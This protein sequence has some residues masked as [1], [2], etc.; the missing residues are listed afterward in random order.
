M[1]IPDADAFLG[2]LR[3]QVRTLARTQRQDPVTVDLLVSTTKRFAS[4]PEHRID[5]H[6]LLASEVDRLR[7]RLSASPPPVDANA[8]GVAQLVAAC[9]S[10]VEPLARILGVLGRWGDG[11]ESDDVANILLTLS[12]QPNS[13]S[14]LVHLHRYPVVLLLWAYGTGLAVA[15]RWRA[16][17]DLLSHPVDADSGE[18]TEPTRLVDIPAR[19]FLDGNRNDFW[20]RLPGLE[21]RKTPASDHIFAVLDTWRTSFAPVVSDFEGLHDIWEIL[22]SL[23]YSETQV[24]EEPNARPPWTHIGRNLWRYRSRRRILERI[25]SDLRRDLLDAG[26]SGGSKT[27]LARTVESYAAFVDPLTWP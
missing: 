8:D 13:Q 3:D 1:R 10:K 26:F 9:E 7:R 18:P 25:L 14:G 22:F 23:T 5:L 27:R 11:A 19:R 16:L 17:H 20:K 2:N 21:E 4:R 6:D 12:T 15:N 24:S